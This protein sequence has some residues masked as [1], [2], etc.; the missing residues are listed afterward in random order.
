MQKN[1]KNS[2]IQ[3]AIKT[4]HVECLKILLAKNMRSTSETR[5]YTPIMFAIRNNQPDAVPLL[6]EAGEDP[7]KF[8]PEK[9]TNLKLLIIFHFLIF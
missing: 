9:I 1:K 2:P 8:T 4:R 5:D 7:G 6:L 3:Q